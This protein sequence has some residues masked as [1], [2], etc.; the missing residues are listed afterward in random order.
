ML[1]GGTVTSPTYRLKSGIFGNCWRRAQR[2]LDNNTS[3]MGLTLK[4]HIVRCYMVQQYYQYQSPTLKTARFLTTSKDA[5]NG[6]QLKTTNDNVATNTANITTNT[7]SIN[8]LTD[9]VGDLKDD[10]LLWNGTS[11]Q[12]RARHRCHQQNHQR[13]RRRPDG[14]QH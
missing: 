13:Q 8:T 12:R 14:W 2:C 1:Q 7:N 4:R 10:A 3:A 5:V 6:S 9:S 11:V